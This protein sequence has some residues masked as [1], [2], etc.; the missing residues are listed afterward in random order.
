MFSEIETRKD[1]AVL[2]GVSYKNLNYLLYGLG[3]ETQYNVFS[4]PKKN[5][6]ERTIAAP[7]KIL[8]KIQKNLMKLLVEQR[9]KMVLDSNKKDKISHAFIKEKS[10]FT[11]ALV[12][13]NKENILNIDLENFFESFHFGRVKGFFNKNKYF[14]AN[15]KIST[16]IAQLTCFQGTLPQGASTSPIITNLIFNIVDM[17]ILELARKYKINYTR[18]ADD[19]TFSTNDTKFPKRLDDFKIELELLIN[20]SGFKINSEKTNFISEQGRQIVTG[21]VVNEKVNFTRE[22]YKKMR[23]VN[24]MY[25]KGE[26]PFI[27]GE[28]LNENQIASHWAYL[29]SIKDFQEEYEIE[30][31]GT[32]KESFSNFSNVRKEYQKFL[33]YNTF[34]DK[35]LP[36]IVVEGKTDKRYLEAALKK[37]YKEFPKLVSYDP[38]SDKFTFNFSFMSRSKTKQKYLSISL[39]GASGMNSILKFITDR[40]NNE[41][42]PNYYMHFKK[43]IEN[44]EISPTILLF[45][46][47]MGKNM[48]L[49]VATSLIK[50]KD[51][52]LQNLQDNYFHKINELFYIFTNPNNTDTNNSEIEDLFTEETLNHTIEGKRFH[53]GSA[54]DDQKHYSKEIFS[55]YVST[56]YEDIDFSSFLP[57]LKALEE[58]FI[59][60]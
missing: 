57:L 9:E 49:K 33:F 39:E 23:S 58:I 25:F 17:E 30:R 32:R 27:N 50:L 42:Y 2:L 24:Y 7:K 55:H 54:F 29:N 1:L 46:N 14:N 6:G 59:D 52:D 37:H 26:T 34:F 56:N 4:I 12:H 18:Y 40:G 3:V 41:G 44:N 38:A 5:G 22:Y 43:Q 35:E 28:Q 11:N 36:L 45:D 47:E 19:L 48:P 15:D 16:I 60:Y 31:F 51:E 13:R 53:R 21:L 20:K 8:K 10:I